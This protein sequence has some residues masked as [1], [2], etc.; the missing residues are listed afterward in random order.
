MSAVDQDD[1]A[2]LQKLILAFF[3]Q[4][5]VRD[6]L[7]LPWSEQQLRGEMFAV[8]ELLGERTD[9]EGTFLSVRGQRKAIERLRERIAQARKNR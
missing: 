6:D 9:V 7:F 5:L 8:C 2:T 4:R 3:A 1:I